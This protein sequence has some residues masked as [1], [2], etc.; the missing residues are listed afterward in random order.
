MSKIIDE[1]LITIDELYPFI[2]HQIYNT[3][4][5]FCSLNTSTAQKVASDKKI[6]VSHIN[7]IIEAPILLHLYQHLKIE[8]NAMD[9]T[10]NCRTI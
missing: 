9:C 6:T 7:I 5:K 3:K 8:E 10:H 4:T 2:S 1:M